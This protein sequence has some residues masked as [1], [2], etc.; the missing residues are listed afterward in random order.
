MKCLRILLTTILFA[1]TMQGL[2][3]HA[4]TLNDVLF[5][6]ACEELERADRY[7]QAKQKLPPFTLRIDPVNDEEWIDFA[8]GTGKRIKGKTGDAA[9]LKVV[10]AEPLPVYPL[11]DTIC[12]TDTLGILRTA[13]LLLNGHY[14]Y[15]RQCL[16]KTCKKQ[17]SNTGSMYVQQLRREGNNL[18]L[19]FSFAGTPDL[20]YCQYDMVNGKPELHQ[21]KVVIPEKQPHM[22]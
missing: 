20:F 18:Y 10:H 19:F 3:L 1:C 4:Q 11:G 5:K 15:V 6:K 14:F 8:D 12:I 7:W 21:S 9:L 16:T 22:E 13:G 2:S 17:L